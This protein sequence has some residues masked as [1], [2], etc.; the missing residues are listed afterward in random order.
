MFQTF[1]KHTLFWSAA[2]G[3]GSWFN[4]ASSLGSIFSELP[5]CEVQQRSC[6]HPQLLGECG[7]C[8]AGIAQ[9]SKGTHS[10]AFSGVPSIKKHLQD[11]VERSPGA[12]WGW[13]AWQ[14]LGAHPLERQQQLLF[15]QNSPWRQRQ[16]H[17]PSILQRK[18]EQ[19]QLLFYTSASLTPAHSPFESPAAISASQFS[20]ES[21]SS[22]S[23]CLGFPGRSEE[24]KLQQLRAALTYLSTIYSFAH[25]ICST[26]HKS[27]QLP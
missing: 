16:T 23:S 26:T 1:S 20:L 5:G 17:H 18:Q 19:T 10:I 8:G 7:M 15:L 12:G 11:K 14:D 25:L 9:P 22:S 13:Q 3:R 6:T 24:V 4:P 2:A 27:M 21:G